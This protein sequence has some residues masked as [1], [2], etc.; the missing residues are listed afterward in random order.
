MAWLVANWQA[1]LVAVL[2]IDQAL[3]PIFPKVTLFESVANFLS[4]AK[5]N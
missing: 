4:K 2:A 3:I 1:V 5:G